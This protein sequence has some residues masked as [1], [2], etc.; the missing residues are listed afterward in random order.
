MA[1]VIELPLPSLMW[2][3]VRAHSDE[4]GSCLFSGSL[5][6]PIPVSTKISE[7]ET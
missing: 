5:I 3:H 7:M 1:L 4:S 2:T 6:M